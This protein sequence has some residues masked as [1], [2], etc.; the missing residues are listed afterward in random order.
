MMKTVIAFEEV[1]PLWREKRLVDE[2]DA[3]S[4]IEETWDSANGCSLT[5]VSEAKLLR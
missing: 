5:A 4:R 1:G 3:S 2:A